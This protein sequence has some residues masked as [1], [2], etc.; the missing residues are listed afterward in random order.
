M[1]RVALVKLHRKGKELNLL[2][3]STVNIVG[4]F[5][6]PRDIKFYGIVSSIYSCGL[7][8][9]FQLIR[10]IHTNNVQTFSDCAMNKSKTITSRCE[11]F[12][13]YKM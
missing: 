2:K 12:L 4:H 1:H 11:Q 13:K 9:D 10:T 7:H 5:N 8:V 3:E 6:V